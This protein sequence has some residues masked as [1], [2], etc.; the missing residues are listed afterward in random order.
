LWWPGGPGGLGLRT[1]KVANVEPELADVERVCAS[2]DIPG[3]CDFIGA[4]RADDRH[5]LRGGR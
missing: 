4:N 1:S 2:L 5:P 3:L